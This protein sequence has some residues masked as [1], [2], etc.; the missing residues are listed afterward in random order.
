MVKHWLVVRI[1]CLRVVTLPYVSGGRHHDIVA[2]FLFAVCLYQI[3][4]V[5]AIQH[6]VGGFS[7]GIGYALQRIC[8]DI[9]TVR[10]C[11]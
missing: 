10:R 8:I 5:G 11:L 6:F 2:L 4:G 7:I 1:M 9:L 3:L